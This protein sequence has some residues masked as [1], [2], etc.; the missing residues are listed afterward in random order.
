MLIIILFFI[1]IIFQNII[2]KFSKKDCF[3]K[4][5]FFIVLRYSLDK[6]HIVLPESTAKINIAKL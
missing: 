5:S 2:S 6:Y 4:Q 1:K 3:A